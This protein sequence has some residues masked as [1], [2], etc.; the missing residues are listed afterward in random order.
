VSRL[1]GV[2][3]DTSAWIAFFAP[4]GH[5]LLKSEVRGALQEERVYTCPVVTCELLVGARDRK[6][7]AKLADLL[8]ALPAAP[9]DRETWGRAADL[10]FSLRRKGHS[11]PLPDLLIAEACRDAS[12]ALW[13]LDEHFETIARHTRIQ[14]RSFSQSA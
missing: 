6:A 7:F 4:T 2:L 5:S 10:G 13:H 9:I 12:V 14:T 11:V 3:L 8:A 1:D